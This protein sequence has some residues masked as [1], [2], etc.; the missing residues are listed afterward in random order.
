MLGD[1]RRAKDAVVETVAH[2]EGIGRV[3]GQTLLG[4][5]GRERASPDAMAREAGPAVPLEG[6]LVEETSALF[7]RFARHVSLAAP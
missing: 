4:V 6:L 1:P 7:K 2:E 5:L 3:C